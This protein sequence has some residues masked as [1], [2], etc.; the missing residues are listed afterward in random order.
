[1]NRTLEFVVDGQM[2]TRVD[3]IFVAS[4]SKNYLKAHFEFL[5]DE[6]KGKIFPI[7]YCKRVGRPKRPFSLSLDENNECFI[8]WEVLALPGFFEVVVT[9][10]DLITTNRV[11]VKIYQG[12]DGD[13]DRS[14]D[15]YQ[16]T[17]DVLAQTKA[18]KIAVKGNVIKLKSGTTVVCTARIAMLDELKREID[19]L[20][21][22]LHQ[23]KEESSL[24][25]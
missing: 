11:T 21:S 5:S 25:K 1:M 12:T 19:E 4:G 16:K 23:F 9:C 15:P 6:W 17:I 8:P 13:A 3:D 18:D 10:G 7:F 14:A 24:K 20:K 22:Q 2:I